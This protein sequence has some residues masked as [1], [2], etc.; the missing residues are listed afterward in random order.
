MHGVKKHFLYSLAVLALA[1]CASGPSTFSP[2]PYPPDVTP[3]YLVLTQVLDGSEASIPGPLNRLRSWITGGRPGIIMQKPTDV[4]VDEAGRLLVVDSEGGE[5]LVYEVH[6]DGWELSRHQQIPGLAH[7]LCIESGDGRIFLTGLASPSISV[8]DPALRVIQVWENQGFVRPGDMAYDAEDQLLYVAD[9]AAHAVFKLSMDGKLQQTIGREGVPESLLH[10]PT[11]VT[12][13]QGEILALDGIARKVKRYS[14]DGVWISSFGEYDRV[15]GSLAFPK[16]ICVSS[17]RV[18]FVCDAAFANVQ[19]FDRG[20]ALLFMIGQTGSQPGE[21]L[22]PRNI[23]MDGSQ[24]LYV[25]DPYNNR[26]QIFQYASQ[27]N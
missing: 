21:F 23:Y 5:I 2:I 17:D 6:A 27:D 25:A 15:P 24:R 10:F 19:L 14:K 7:P 18:L 26:V 13:D 1:G 4:V 9:P 16:G 22:M 3:P 11:G 12:V 20:G 8:L